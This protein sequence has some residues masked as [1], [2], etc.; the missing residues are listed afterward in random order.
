MLSAHYGG[1]PA[2]QE[3]VHRSREFQLNDSA[4]Y[5]NAIDRMSL[6]SYLPTDQDILRSRIKTTGITETMFTVGEL[7]YCRWPAKRTE[8]V[9]LLPRECC[10]PCVFG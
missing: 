2:M 7:T 3:A 1:D 6:L 8:E 10:C 9:D 4:Y 5:L